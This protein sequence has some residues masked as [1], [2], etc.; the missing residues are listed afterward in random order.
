MIYVRPLTLDLGPVYSSLTGVL[1]HGIFSADGAT[2]YLPLTTAGIAETGSGT[3]SYFVGANLDT[4]WGWVIVRWTAPSVTRQVAVNA[5]DNVPGLS[6]VT[7]T[8]GGVDPSLCHYDPS[9]ALP[10]DR[11]RGRCGDTNGLPR[12]FLSDLAITNLIQVE[13]SEDEAAAKC[14][15]MIGAQ[16]IQMADS[17]D[18][19]DLKRSYGDRA[20]KSFELAMQIRH[21]AK[22]VRSAPGAFA[23]PMAV[24]VGYDDMVS[25]LSYPNV[26]QL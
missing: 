23:G 22:P 25:M 7:P 6:S 16:C 3:G 18:S 13:Q 8:L 15:E 1:K 24:P 20:K 17:T 2:T 26:V 5:S 21:V 12:W 9:Q 14:C 10:K 4:S 19:V 11:V